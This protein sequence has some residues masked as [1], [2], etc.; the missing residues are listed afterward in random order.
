MEVP[1]ES[2]HWSSWD[3]RTCYP[4][5]AFIQGLSDDIM[6]TDLY[7]LCPDDETFVMEPST[8]RILESHAFWISFEEV[9]G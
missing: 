8:E 9:I 6:L 5:R 4:R 3:S 2:F 7:L 1:S